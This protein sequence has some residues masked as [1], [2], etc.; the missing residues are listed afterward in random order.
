MTGTITDHRPPLR[1]LL[2]AVL[3]AAALWW[4][5]APAAGAA[6]SV[7]RTAAV[8]QL[9]QVRQSIDQTLERVKSGDAQDA[10]AEAKSGYL[11]HFELVEIPLRV[12]APRLTA[13]AETKFAEI[14]GLISG[15]APT[16]QIRDAVIEL[17]RLINDSERE[18]TSTGLGAPSVV[19]GQSFLIIFREGLEAVLLL[20]ALLGYLEAAK[21]SQYRKPVVIG[22]GAAVA[23]SVVIF[24]VLRVVLDSL[25]FGREVLEAVTAIV[26]TVVL[27]YV[28]FWL[29]ARLEQRRWLEFLRSRVWSAVSVGSTTA[30]VLVGFTAVF[31]EGFETS[32][33]YQ[34]LVSFGTGLVGWILLGLALGLAALTVVAYGIFKLGR[35]LPIKTFLSGAVVL[36]MATSVAFL[37]NAVR[38]LQ[39]ADVIG[40][41]PL[42]GWP[43]APIFLS[44]ALGYWPS[45]ETVLTQAA[46]ALVY[47]AGAVYMFVI[48][49]RAASK[50]PARPKEERAPVR[51][52]ARQPAQQL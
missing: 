46:L 23:A 52:P 16:G 4:L 34:A 27:F 21:A 44:Q 41:T 13:D 24:F 43:R 19:A 49:P 2:P 25:P 7:S 1:R 42:H 47:V 30:L 50:P 29:I 8:R 6:G 22:M 39:E 35:K 38:S 17:R 9:D 45:K 3:L 11:N 48:R 28:S 36:L 20:S 18:L 51:A 10:F 26:A 12:V 14:R 31:R 32:L 37:G 5:L 40:L 33:M 15:G